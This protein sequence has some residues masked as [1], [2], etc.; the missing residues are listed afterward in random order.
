MDIFKGLNILTITFYVCAG[1]FQGLS[2]AFHYLIQLLTFL[3]SSL[4]LP[5]NF[6]N[7]FQ[8][9]Q[10]SLLCDWSNVLWCRPLLGWLQGNCAR[11]NLSQAASGMILQ[12]HSRFPV[13]IFGVQIAALRS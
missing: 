1:G 4:K 10:N 12:N 9:P 6:E 8:N 3:F 13:S 7:A 11:I 2:K 5:T